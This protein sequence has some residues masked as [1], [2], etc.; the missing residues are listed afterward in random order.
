MIKGQN[1]FTF[2]DLKKYSL[3]LYEMIGY[4]DF[5]EKI[6]EI[7]HELREKYPNVDNLEKEI[8][9]YFDEHSKKAA[10][11]TLQEMKHDI[12]MEEQLSIS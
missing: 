7:L 1:K 12:S 11:K 5:R 3:Y 8:F 9:E 10:K 6:K 4:E 2:E